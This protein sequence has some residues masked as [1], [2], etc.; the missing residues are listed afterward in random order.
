LRVAYGS[1][2]ALKQDTQ[3]K[4]TEIPE[5][6]L[7]GIQ[8]LHEYLKF[9]NVDLIVVPVPDWEEIAF[10]ILF[11]EYEG[12]LGARRLG[13]IKAM[14]DQS[15][16]CV[17]ATEN[18]TAA[19]RKSHNE[20]F[21][22]YPSDSHPYGKTHEVIVDMLCERLQRYAFWEKPPYD[23]ARFSVQHEPKK[24]A[25]YNMPGQEKNFSFQYPL[26]QVHLDGNPLTEFKDNNASII[27]AGNS[28]TTSGSAA[29]TA[30]ALLAAKS[31]HLPLYLYM[32]GFLPDFIATYLLKNEAG[33]LQN[34]RVVILYMQM[35]NL[36]RLRPFAN[37]R[38]RM[39]DL[40]ERSISLTAQCD[41]MAVSLM[42]DEQTIIHSPDDPRRN[43]DT[44]NLNLIRK[45]KTLTL[46]FD[47]LQNVQSAGPPAWYPFPHNQ[48][49]RVK[50]PCPDLD[51][52]EASPG[53]LAFSL[54][55]FPGISLI[56]INHADGKEILRDP[57]SRQ[58][59]TPFFI[60]V[61]L[62][63]GQKYVELEINALWYTELALFT[64]IQLHY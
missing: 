8:E 42:M 55:C 62:L 20:L 38:K 29:P 5:T 31:G 4:D 61:N 28:F 9:H 60:P 16:E 15:I 63:P 21:F 58:H 7:Q 26:Y 35:F 47:Q 64:N 43:L 52:K 45:E 10:N 18:L 57:V 51:L 37:V 59:Y 46:F 1:L 11:P 2:L 27:L 44:A 32:N 30:P 39:Q 40:Y 3:I 50:F 22:Y 41:I 19:W 6:S 56:R 24:T 13:V 48:G 33:W 23:K 17:D 12:L 34:R 14:S 49:I 53:I 25:T 54:L 36:A